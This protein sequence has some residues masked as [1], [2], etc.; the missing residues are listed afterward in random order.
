M[1]TDAKRNYA[2]KAARVRCASRG[3]KL[4]YSIIIGNCEYRLSAPSRGRG[5]FPTQFRL[6]VLR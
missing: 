4:P 1:Y 2:A 3:R 5:R 6:A